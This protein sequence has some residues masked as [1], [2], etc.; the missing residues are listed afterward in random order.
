MSQPNPDPMPGIRAVLITGFLSGNVIGLIYL[1]LEGHLGESLRLNPVALF[2]AVL[3]VGI[4]GMMVGAACGL[5]LR[6]RLEKRGAADVS[7]G[8]LVVS[9]VA[10]AFVGFVIASAVINALW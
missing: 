9:A 7:Q 5:F 4:A 6:L 1:A 3:G 10:S 2:G 8:P